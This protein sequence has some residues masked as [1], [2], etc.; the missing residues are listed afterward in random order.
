MKDGRS[1]LTLWLSVCLFLLANQTFLAAV[2]SEVCAVCGKPITD[3]YYNFEDQVTQEKKH[4]CK[5]CEQSYPECFVCGLPADTNATGFITLPDQRALCARDATTAVLRDEE[6]LRICREVRD[7]LDRLFSRFTSFPDTNVTVRLVDRV[8][9]QELFRLVGNDYHCPN[10]WGMTQT[11]TNRNRL[12]FEISLMSG[13][14]LN[15]FQATC[16]HEYSHTWVGEH[17]SP[18][19]KDGLSRDAEEGFCELVS[20]LYMDSLNDEAQKALILRNAYTRGQI[21][22][23][24][25]AQRNFGFNEVLDWMQFG[26]DD[27]LSANEPGRIRKIAERR[28]PGATLS[29][30]LRAATPAPAPASLTLKAIFWDPK[31]PTAL[32]N[33]RTFSPSQESTVRVGTSNVLVRCLSIAE[34]SVRLRVAGSDHEQTLRLK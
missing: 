8:H 11:T 3:V 28:S 25:A 18:A 12:Q 27:R 29:F 20:F 19:R 6:G 10:V 14:P 32:I 26:L 2:D 5:N 4:V 34:D 15:W 9:L 24:V 30:V 31:Q 23:F 33:D 16:A 13:L 21:D 17:V 22:L 7:G 1:R